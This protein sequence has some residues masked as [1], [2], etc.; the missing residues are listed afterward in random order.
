MP[1]ATHEVTKND[2][3]AALE[4]LAD[5]AEI[6]R[7]RLEPFP[8]Q[9]I[10]LNEDEHNESESPIMDV[11][12][13]TGGENAILKMANFSRREFDR[14]WGYVENHISTN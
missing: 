3:A 14:I 11:F 12:V 10:H 8:T 5:Q 9:P 1:P 13:E 7:Q 6:R 2:A 4:L